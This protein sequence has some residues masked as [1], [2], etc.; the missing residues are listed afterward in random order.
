MTKLIK[1]YGVFTKSMMWTLIVLASFSYNSFSETSDWDTVYPEDTGE[2]LVNPGMGWVLHFYDNS[3]DVYGSRLEPSD[4]IDDFPGLSVIYLRIAWSFLE[5]EEGQFNWSI[6]DTPAQRWI[7]KGKRIALRITC[8]ETP[9][10]WATPKWVN[11][12]GAKG[13]FFEP[14]QGIKENG[15]HWEPD[16]NDPIFLEKLDHFLEALARRYD[17]NPSVDFIDIGSLGVWGEGHTW[18]STRNHISADTVKKHIDLHL[19]HFKNTIIALN[20]DSITNGQKIAELTP[21]QQEILNY[22]KE[23][24]LTLRDDSILVQGGENAYFSASLAPTFWRNTPVILESAHYAHSKNNGYWGDGSKYLQAVE[25]YHAS[26]VSV[27]WWPHEF[28]QENKEL[29]NKINIRLGYRLMPTKIEWQNTVKISDKKW[30]IHYSWANKGVAPCYQDAYPI[31]TWKDEKGGIVAV[32]CDE[33][34]NVKQLPIGL[35]DVERKVSFLLPVLLKEGTYTVSISVGSR[36]GTPII[37]LPLP[38]N[39]GTKRYAIGQVKVVP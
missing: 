21:E 4:T 1:K 12:A 19:K 24:G 26:Y 10:P 18:S 3:P 2:S 34:F 22:A 15:T 39:D 6:L 11:N 7:A 36:I 35:P 30:E 37:Q 25:D 20:D 33:D 8:S 32:F 38:D 23:K 14:E 13:Y 29:I 17:G 16:Y 27:H 31:I 28:L 5:P 9:T